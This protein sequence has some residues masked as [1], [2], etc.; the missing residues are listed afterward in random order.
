MAAAAEAAALDVDEEDR[1]L[2][3]KGA[4]RWP[5]SEGL[6]EWPTRRHS[7]RTTMD[8]T[9]RGSE[10]ER[11]REPASQP[12]IADQLGPIAQSWRWLGNY[13]GR[14]LDSRKKVVPMM[15]LLLLLFQRETLKKGSL[16]FI[17]N[18][19]NERTAR[20][21]CVHKWSDDGRQLVE[22]NVSNRMRKREIEPYLPR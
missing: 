10:R 5:D 8:G 16:R 4:R 13:L 6:A 9:M 20:V 19:P 15:L 18:T 21:R 17:L 14:D 1:D 22:R 7:G 3:M 2:R 11:E 12:Q